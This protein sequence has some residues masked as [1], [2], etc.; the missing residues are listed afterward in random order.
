MEGEQNSRKKCD[1][2]IFVIHTIGIENIVSCKKLN[3]NDV[4]H[5]IIPLV[6]TPK[7]LAFYV[8]KASLQGVA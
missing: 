6:T 7:F 5:D 2:G 4:Y 1:D 3:T 8:A